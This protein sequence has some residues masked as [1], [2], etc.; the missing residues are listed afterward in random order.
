MRD[1]GNMSA[2]TALFVL[3]DTLAEAPAEAPIEAPRGRLLM[4]AMGPGFTAAFILLEVASDGALE[5]A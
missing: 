4:S 3:K 2:A 5:G 1:Y